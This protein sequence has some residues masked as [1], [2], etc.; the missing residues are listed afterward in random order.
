MMQVF[1][2]N[3]KGFLVCKA[4]PDYQRLGEQ[5]ALLNTVAVS[6]FLLVL[7]PDSPDQ[8]TPLLSTGVNRSTQKYQAVLQPRLEKH[9]LRWHARVK[10]S[11]EWGQKDIIILLV[12][13]AFLSASFVYLT[14]SQLTTY[15]VYY[16]S[17]G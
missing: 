5:S 17:L 13:A 12:V 14:W 10:D 16:I 8:L 6:I 3:C 2:W 15:N 9:K 11:V 7:L 1:V 4:S